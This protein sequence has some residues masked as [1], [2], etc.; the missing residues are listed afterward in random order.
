MF[1]AIFLL[2][3]SHKS[4]GGFPRW[5]VA[6]RKLETGDSTG[7]SAFLLPRASRAEL[8]AHTDGSFHVLRRESLEGMSSEDRAALLEVLAK[9]LSDT[10]RYAGVVDV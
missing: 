1:R 8:R 2:A 4:F 6:L 9:H 5:G 7:A 3:F 10:C